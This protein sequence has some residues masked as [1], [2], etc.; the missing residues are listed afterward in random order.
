MCRT[1]MRASRTV[2]GSGERERDPEGVQGGEFDDDAI[3]YI[4]LFSLHHRNK[5]DTPLTFHHLEQRALLQ[6]LDGLELG[7]VVQHVPVQLQREA[8]AVAGVLPVHQHLVDLLH[9]FL[10]RY[11]TEEEEDKVKLPPFFGSV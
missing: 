2:Y 7:E 11:L 10:G 9:H 5:T 8:G 6:A 4:Y 1:W 3:A